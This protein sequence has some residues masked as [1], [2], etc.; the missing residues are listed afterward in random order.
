M[1]NFAM[2]LTAMTAY[3]T[4]SGSQMAA[5]HDGIHVQD[6]YARVSGET[7]KSAAVFMTLMNHS[8]EDDRLLSV[9]SDAAERAEL[10]THT[11]DTN[12]VMHVGEVTEG[13]PIAGQEA[14]LLDRGGD[15]IMLLGLKQGLKQGD[16]VT[17]TL[18][19]ARGDDVVVEVPVDNDRKPGAIGHDMESMEMPASN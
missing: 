2:F 3:F 5:A 4:L 9:T 16:I 7:A 13:F 8:I 15:H 1:S 19:F 12:G 6:A 10:H 18:K 17:V 11:L 14:H